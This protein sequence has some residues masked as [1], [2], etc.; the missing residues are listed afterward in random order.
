[1]AKQVAILIE[2]MYNEYEF[3]YPYYRMI[4]AGCEVTVVGTGRKKSYPSKVGLPAEETISAVNADPARFDA[5]IIPG[6]FAP[7]FMR[8]DPAMVNLV[9]EV[10]NRGGVVAA[11]C[12]GGWMLASA[13]IVKGK[14]VTSFFAIKDDLINAGAEYLDR[15]VVVDGNLVTSRMPG[16]LPA[17]CK[18][19][20]EKM[21]LV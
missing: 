14:Q 3:I 7:D 12:H 2:E 6:G 11:I 17:F 4:E 18:A 10:Y 8:R 15:E 16:D 19:V 1:M 21:G 9:R 13:G 20:L 5:V